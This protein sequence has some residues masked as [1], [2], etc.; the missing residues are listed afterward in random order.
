MSDLGTLETQIERD[1]EN[2]TRTLDNLTSTLS[3]DHIATRV[4][5]SVEGYG[6]EL[7]RQAWDS[8]K[9]NPAAFALVVAGIGL[10]ISGTGTRSKAA[11]ATSVT[12]PKAAMA[13]FDER[14]E[15]ADAA[16]KADMAT[17]SAAPKASWLREN[18]HAGLDTLPSSAKARVIK[19]RKAAIVAQEKVEAQAAALARKTSAFHN[20]QP[21]A[22]GAL[23]LGLGAL[24]AALLPATRREDELLGEHRDAM[25]KKAQDALKTEMARISQSAQDGMQAALNSGR[26]PSPGRRNHAS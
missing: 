13:G 19:V 17:E 14:V 5:S 18:L 1:R 12:P 6:G 25:M 4:A 2:L 8:A 9:K 20:D 22:V 16:M 10:L 15:E 3:P 26:T 7:G 21:L 23:A 24:V 11:P